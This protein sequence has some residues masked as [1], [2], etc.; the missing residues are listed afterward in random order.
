MEYFQ[1]LAIGLENIP[2]IILEG[3][4]AVIGG[5]NY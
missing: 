2:V 1:S 5:I 3:Y 4:S